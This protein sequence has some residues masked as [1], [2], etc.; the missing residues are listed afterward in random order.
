MISPE[1]LRRLPCF[2]AVP[3]DT[4]ASVAMMSEEASAA[5]GTL[6]FNER[7]AADVLSIIIEGEID[8]QQKLDNCDVRTV[9]TLISG[10]ILGWSAMVE[11]HRMTTSAICRK[12]TRLIRIDAP[13]LRQ[14]CTQDP[15]LGYR[16]MSQI[17][18]CL[19][20]RLEAARVQLA[21]GA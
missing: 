12:P 14:L 21:T 11:P 1:L 6:L 2:S 7:D 13:R 9:D 19:A 17:A 8:I 10:D 4:L 20:D 16:L 3:E 15:S 18:V 5:T